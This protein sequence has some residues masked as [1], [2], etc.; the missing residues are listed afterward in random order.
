MK[1]F[2]PQSPPIQD[3]RTRSSGFSRVCRFK[4]AGRPSLADAEGL[5]DLI[6][7]AGWELLL[8]VGF[9]RFSL[10]RLARFARIGKPTI[11]SRFAN[12]E[13]LL[14]ALSIRQIELRHQEVIA[15][16]QGLSI[17]EALPALASKVVELFL[18]PE[19]RLI[20]RLIDWLDYEA[21]R[22][23]DSLRGWAMQ[24]AI[25]NAVAVLRHAGERGEIAIADPLS[26]ARFFIEG[27]VGHARITDMDEDACRSR[28]DDWARQLSAMILGHFGSA[29]HG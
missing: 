29:P 22:S 4:S 26:A 17:N 18:S 23:Q 11:Y 6:L 7:D 10:D 13:G 1:K 25:D 28:H 15:G 3:G 2:A 5:A 19:G 20:D 8:D 21:E 24:A 12:K 14:R 27:I 16:T 9:E